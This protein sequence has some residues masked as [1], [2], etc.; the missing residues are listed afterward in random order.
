VTTLLTEPSQTTKPTELL[1]EISIENQ[2]I[3]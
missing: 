3:Q 1:N 2:D